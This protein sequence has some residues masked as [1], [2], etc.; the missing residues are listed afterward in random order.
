MEYICNNRDE[1]FASIALDEADKST[2]LHN[3]GCVAV[4]G[5][6]IMAK[7][8]NSDRCYSSDGFL[9]NTCSCHAEIDVIRQLDKIL[10]KKNRDTNES[11]LYEKVSLY[12]VRKNNNWEEKGE[13][14]YKDSAPCAR[15]THYMKKL[16]IKYI[17]YSN[18][19]GTLTKCK[20]KDYNTEHVSQGNR[21]L[22]Y[23]MNSIY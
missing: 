5:G 17:I 10:K 22:N 19:K 1:R 11:S 3:H 15:C 7:G 9:N 4:I 20:V 2:M 12:V 18:N 13:S 21:Y 8:F 16:K 14:E 6:R 23:R